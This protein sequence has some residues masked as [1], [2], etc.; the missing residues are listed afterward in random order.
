[1]FS[2]KHNA[3]VDRVKKALINYIDTRFD[4]ASKT[5]KDY[6]KHGDLEKAREYNGMLTAYNDIL[7]FII[8]DLK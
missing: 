4:A 3:D 1:M 5:G 7:H 6:L 2:K 8:N